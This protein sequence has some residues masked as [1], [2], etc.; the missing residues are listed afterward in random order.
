M[1]APRGGTHDRAIRNLDLLVQAYRMIDRGRTPKESELKASRSST[2]PRSRYAVGDKVWQSST[3]RWVH[4]KGIVVGVNGRSYRIRI[5]TVSPL[6]TSSPYEVGKTY[7]F[8]ESE[9]TGLQ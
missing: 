2:Q 3:G 9:I 7:D 5:T 6:A 8:V 4:W 1:R